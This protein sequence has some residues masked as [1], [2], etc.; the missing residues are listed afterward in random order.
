MDTVTK[1][2]AAMG[3]LEK[4]ISGLPG[5]KGYRE[6]EM[7][8]DADKQVRDQLARELAER[9]AKI[10]ALQ[11]ELLESGGLLWLDDVERAVGRLQLLIDRIKTAAR[12]YA[13]FFDLQRVKEAELDRLANFDQALFDDLPKLDEGIAALA[14][15][16]AE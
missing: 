8:R 2:K 3:G 9:R 6:K 14:Q 10:T 13:G 11:S 15:A 16:V 1:A 4:A 7:R 12:G 5:I